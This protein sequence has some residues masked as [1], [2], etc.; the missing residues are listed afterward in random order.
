MEDA[1]V[2]APLR[3]KLHEPFRPSCPCFLALLE[4]FRKNVKYR[5]NI[6][7]GIATKECDRLQKSSTLSNYHLERRRSYNRLPIRSTLAHWVK[8]LVET[9][10]AIP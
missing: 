6:E 1:T 2:C 9:A 8:I 10:W 3:V 7:D 5:L 4:T